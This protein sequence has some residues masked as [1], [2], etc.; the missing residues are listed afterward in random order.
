M[1][2]EYTPPKYA[3]LISSCSGAWRA[4]STRQGLCC[5]RSI[6]SRLSSRWPGPRWCGRDRV[7]RQEGWIETQQGKGSFVR[8]RPA[9]AG[10]ASERRGQAELDLDE[11]R[12]DGELISAGLAAAPARIASMLGVGDGTELGRRRLLA[13]REGEP[14]EI[15]TWWFPSALAQGTGLDGP[16]L[17]RGGVRSLMARVKGVRVDHGGG[18]RHGQA[19]RAA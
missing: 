16:E 15:V 4:A 14:S 17:L 2:F 8:G 1:A 11:S 6:S 7:L 10:V 3:Q 19:A 5:H 12:E 18:D 13:R 9:L